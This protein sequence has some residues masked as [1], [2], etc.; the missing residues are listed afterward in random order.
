MDLICYL[1]PGWAPTSARPAPPATGWTTPELSFAYRCLPLNIANAH[2][3]EILAPVACDAIWHGGPGLDDVQ[4]RVAPGT[5][6]KDGPV[7]TFGEG[8]LTFHINGTVPHPARLEPVGRR[9]TQ[10]PEGRDL[11]ADRSD[12]D[13]LVA[14]HVHDELALHAT[15]SPGPLRRRRADL[16]H[17]PGAAHGPRTGHAAVPA[18]GVRAGAG[19][20]LRRLEQFP[21][22]SFL[23]P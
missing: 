23:K 10:Q 13:R 8:V 6:P 21:P 9:V 18:D 7:S 17:L 16:L 20:P 2:G 4:V 5:D 22:G 14:V 15:Q 11:S 19:R 3:W 12:R 1:R